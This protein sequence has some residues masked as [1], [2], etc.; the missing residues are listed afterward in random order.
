LS[1]HTKN[2]CLLTTA[3]LHRCPDREKA[4]AESTKHKSA[5]KLFFQ[6]NRVVN[7]RLRKSQVQL[8][9]RPPFGCGSAQIVDFQ[10]RSEPE[11]LLPSGDLSLLRSK[12]LHYALINMGRSNC[13]EFVKNSD[14][15]RSFFSDFLMCERRPKNARLSRRGLDV[16]AGF[17]RSLSMHTSK[18]LVT[19]LFL[20]GTAAEL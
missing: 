14:L 11:V 20:A 1:S 2:N 15:R 8:L 7:N 5:C 19:K 9:K 6:K 10:V 13:E 3:N 4:D 17:A 12:N 18:A 16:R